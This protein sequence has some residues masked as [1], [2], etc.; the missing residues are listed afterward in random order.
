MTI[1]NI[2][3]SAILLNIPIMTGCSTDVDPDEQVSEEMPEFPEIHQ[4][5]GQFSLK[6]LNHYAHGIYMTSAISRES[7]MGHE[8]YRPELFQDPMR[9]RAE[10]WLEL[11]GWLEQH[12]S[13]QEGQLYDSYDLNDGV[14]ET[15]RLS[16]YLSTVYHYHMHHR[17]D[18]YEHHQGL[19]ERIFRQPARFISMIGVH[20]LQNHFEDGRFYHDADKTE[21]DHS[22]MSYGLEGIHGHLYAWIRWDKPGGEDDMGQLTEDYL[23]TWL[24][25]APDMLTHHSRQIAETLDQYW[26]EDGGIYDFGSGTTYRL[27]EIGALL[28]G[29]KAVYEMLHMFGGDRDREAIETM[30]ERGTIVLDALIDISEPWGLPAEIR[31]E[32]GGATPASDDVNLTQMYTFLNAMGGGFSYNREREGT[33]ELLHERRPDLLESLGELSDEVLTRS[34]SDW[35]LNNTLVTAVDFD[36]GEITDE[37]HQVGPIGMFIT[38]AGNNY[39]AGEAFERAS[40]WNEVDEETRDRSRELYD[41]IVRHAEFLES[42]YQLPDLD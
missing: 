2:F 41:T 35:Q 27:D 20:L 31:F 39:R 36:S 12:L 42:E 7:E 34:L 16:N 11:T 6:D 30:F 24:R 10:K 17:G 9:E 21:Y 40:D 8:N 14:D 33:S 23:T 26:D 3:I 5:E 4:P 37:R 18:W 1:R 19:D 28:R 22:S 29:K 32:E 25:F 15:F 13:N 38:A